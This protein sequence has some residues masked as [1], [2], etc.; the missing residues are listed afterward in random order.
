MEHDAVVE[1][2]TREL[3]HPLDMLWRE[4]GA[5]QN[6]DAAVLEIEQEDIVERIGSGGGARRRGAKSKQHRGKDCET[7]EHHAEYFLFK[8]AATLAGTKL[9]TSPPMAAIWRTRLAAM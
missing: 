4:I 9:L 2:L 8:A 3:L 1:A 7:S 5:E 6:G